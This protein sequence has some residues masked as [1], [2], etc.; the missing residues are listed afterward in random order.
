MAKASPQKKIP[1]D[2]DNPT[3]ANSNT[4][5]LSKRPGFLVRRLYQ[6]HVALFAEECA[7][8]GLTPVQYSLL[9]ALAGRQQA[10]QTS[11]AADI[12]LDKT[13]TAGA[14]QRLERRGLL[15]RTVSGLDRRARVCMLTA[16]GKALLVKMEPQAR[17]AHRDTIAGLAEHE[18]NA[19][20][21]LLTRAISS[22]G[23]KI[24]P[25]A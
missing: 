10:D 2:R 14:L 25:L 18:Q 19:L 5:P 17:R 8:F 7:Q 20:I 13:T 12:A 6:I 24:L 21:E 1:R 15:R 4:W 3:E 22:H 23:D 9:S 11:L 16:K